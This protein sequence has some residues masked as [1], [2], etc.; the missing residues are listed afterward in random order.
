V[1][2]AVYLCVYAC[3]AVFVIG[4]VVRTIRYARTPIHL[5][6]ELY[7]VPHEQSDRAGHGGSYFETTDWWTKPQHFS[8]VGEVRAMV[9]EIA[10]LQA[11]RESNRPLWYSSVLFHLGLYL[12]TGTAVLILLATMMPSASSRLHIVYSI[13][14]YAAMT[15]TL[16]GAVGLTFRRWTD[17]GS[18]NYTS[19]AD[20][21]NLQ[22]F[23]VACAVLVAGYLVRPPISATV[24]QFTRGLITFDTSLQV[25]RGFGAGIVL[26]AVLIA[27]IPFTHM[28][29]FI[30]KYFSYHRV[31]W[32]DHVNARGGTIERQVA[33]YLQYRPSWSAPHVGADGHKTWA[34]LATTNPSLEVKK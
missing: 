24:V 32:D 31:R 6:W 29:H 18:R 9:P 33:E 5:R 25:G 19:P 20:I 1:T 7:P 4:V 2:I 28:S 17:P 30:A 15:C 23:V 3:L 8:R 13:S 21:F 27:Y 34:E 26:S 12:S 14:G 10:W 22:F 16:F 11:L